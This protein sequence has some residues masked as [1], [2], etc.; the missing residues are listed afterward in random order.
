MILKDIIKDVF[1][2]IFLLLIFSTIFFYI[3]NKIN[4][5]DFPGLKERLL[6]F[7]GIFGVLSFVMNFE[8]L[9]LF[10]KN[11]RSEIII[12]KIR[13]KYRRNIFDIRFNLP[14]LTIKKI[15]MGQWNQHVIIFGLV[16]YL[17]LLVVLF[18][19]LKFNDFMFF[20]LLLYIPISFK[21]R[22][23][24]KIPLIS[25]LLL[26]LLSGL[27]FSQG[28]ESYANVISVYAYYCLVIGISVIFIDY[29]RNSREIF[30]YSDHKYNHPMR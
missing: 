26:L 14:K 15:D 3:Y 10:A 16:P 11:L 28:F 17:A 25:A 23:N 18:N 24:P 20:I 21:L 13:L 8:D 19:F 1:L 29:I 12:Y 4:S 9:M 6:L 5:F 27:I 22:L 7:S 2:N 30:N